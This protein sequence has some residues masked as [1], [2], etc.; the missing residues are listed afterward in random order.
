MNTFLKKQLAA[1]A[2][3]FLAVFALSAQD[4]VTPTDPTV[5]GDQFNL[6]G[7]LEF[8]KKA[9]TLE[10]FEKALNQPENEVNNLDLN[11][12]G[13]T[14]YI[15]L[16]DRMDGDAHAIVLQAV[17]SE[18]ETQDVAV[19]E[20]EK[21][22]DDAAQLQIIGDEDLY[23]ENTLVEPYEEE[24][25]T[26]K[27]GRGG[28][29]AYEARTYRIVVNVWLW[30]SVRFVYGPVYRPYFSPWRWRWYPVWYRPFRPRPYPVFYGCHRPYRVHYHVVHDHYMHRAHQ[31][32]HPHR[33]SAPMVRER[34]PVHRDHDRDNGYR[35]SNER[36]NVRP[37]GRN[38]R[39]PERGDDKGYRRD[40]RDNDRINR[41]DRPEQGREPR[42]AT[43]N[44]RS[45]R[46]YDIP[47]SRKGDADA[48]KDADR[49]G[50]RERPAPER[51]KQGVERS[52]RN[53]NKE[54]SAK[55]GG[56]SRSR[57]SEGRSG[58]R[59]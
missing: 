9:S 23:G 34:Y 8:F 16:D 31:A 45:K 32:Y 27:T 12:D 14:D 17:L 24:V 57:K 28:P 1:T 7:A 21:T 56:Q 43:K 11:D 20:I 22:G 50:R 19:I 18:H 38:Q 39:P 37:D 2:L 25:K 48:R 42:K 58:S 51:N 3:L 15:R 4:S 6:E 54:K 41:Q 49:M 44:E 40:N 47:Q 55:G 46:D 59:Q 29:V 13:E 5:P 53:S 52:S 10:D 30:P 26:N 36:S 33:H 35:K